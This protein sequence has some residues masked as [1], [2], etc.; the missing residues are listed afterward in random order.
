LAEYV[1]PIEDWLENE[2]RFATRLVGN[3]HLLRFVAILTVA[4]WPMDTH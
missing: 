4:G 2:Y 3:H 1:T